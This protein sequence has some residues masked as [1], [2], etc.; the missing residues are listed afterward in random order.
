MDDNP[1]GLLMAIAL[2]PFIVFLGWLI[3]TYI[4]SI[5]KTTASKNWP[6][7]TGQILSSHVHTYKRRRSG[8]GHATMHK[9]EITYE[10]TADGQ[11]YESQKI[12][13]GSVAASSVAGWAKEIV[14]RYP[15]GSSVQVFYNSSKPAESIL[16]PSGLGGNLVLMI[17]LSA[18][19]LVL[20]SLG[21][22][23]LVS[24]L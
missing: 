3:S 22:A 5:R 11:H 17:A 1:G 16:E 9:P 15:E 10:Y 13:F 20:I 21:V 18:I 8:G 19:E 23:A 14:A 24:Y 2:L 12:S 6:T 7:A 4:R